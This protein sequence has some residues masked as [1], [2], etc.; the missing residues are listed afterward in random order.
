MI[1]VWISKDETANVA[2]IVEK[3]NALVA[4][5][6]GKSDLG[7]RTQRLLRGFVVFA[8][9]ARQADA[10]KVCADKKPEKISVSY[11]AADK[12]AESEPYKISADVKNTIYLISGKK[13][14]AKFIDLT[15]ADFDK[16][17]KAAAELK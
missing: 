3:L 13:V 4:E 5:K 7:D 16:V 12:K 9:S 11:L 6:S 10:D 17:V 2:A 14:Q 1:Q 8:D 15:A